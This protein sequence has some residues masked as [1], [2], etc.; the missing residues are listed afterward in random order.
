MLRIEGRTV[1]QL[2]SEFRRRHMQ[3]ARLS[4]QGPTLEA[5]QPAC[6]VALGVQDIVRDMVQYTDRSGRHVSNSQDH[7]SSYESPKVGMP[8]SILFFLSLAVAQV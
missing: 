5:G 7:N 3:P 6:R 1:N 4:Y 8:P 2:R